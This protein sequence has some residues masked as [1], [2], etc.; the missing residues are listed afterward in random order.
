[1]VNGPVGTPDRQN[2]RR[3]DDSLTW[4]GG[5]SLPDGKTTVGSI[6]A[7]LQQIK[8]L[9]ERDGWIFIGFMGNEGADCHAQSD[10]GIHHRA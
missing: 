4:V 10:D 9:D 7:E 1:M 8:K 5:L 3:K 2:H 6:W